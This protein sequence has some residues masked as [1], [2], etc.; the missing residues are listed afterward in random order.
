LAIG[1][2]DDAAAREADRMADLVM[3][4]AG[5]DAAPIQSASSAAKMLG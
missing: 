4:D 3:S 5:A 1:Q 2:V